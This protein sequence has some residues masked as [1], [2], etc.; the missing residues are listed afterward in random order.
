MVRRLNT[1]FGTA[2]IPVGRHSLMNSVIL[3]P[4]EAFDKEKIREFADSVKGCFHKVDIVYDWRDFTVLRTISEL[5]LPERED[6]PF[7]RYILH[8]DGAVRY[9]WKVK[10]FRRL[11][12]YMDVPDWYFARDSHDSI[13]SN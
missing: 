3:K 12:A 11:S 13:S 9:P 6:I 1:T 8:A 7:E 2:V 10:A 5:D 4:S